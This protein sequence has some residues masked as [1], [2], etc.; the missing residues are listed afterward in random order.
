MATFFRSS[1]YWVVDYL[2][3]GHPRQ[4]WHSAPTGSDPADTVRR[5]LADLWGDRARLLGLRPATPEEE[6]AYLRGEQPGTRFC[7]SGR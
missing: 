2:Y 6:T 4:R 1:T 3:D 5:E 7:P